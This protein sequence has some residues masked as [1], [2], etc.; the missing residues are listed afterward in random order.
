MPLPYELGRFRLVQPL[1]DDG[2]TA[3]GLYVDAYGQQVTIRTLSDAVAADPASQQAFRQGAYASGPVLE[4]GH[5][6]DGRPFVVGPA[7]PPTV[8][9]TGPAAGPGYPAYGPPKRR[10]WPLVAAICAIVV[11]A[12][13]VVTAVLLTRGDDSDSHQAD[14]ATLV[15]SPTSAGASSTAPSPTPSPTPT[16]D[17]LGTPH[18]GECRNLSYAAG[19]ALS[20]ATPT[21]DCEQTHTA[22]TYYVGRYQGDREDNDYAGY[23]CESQLPH[24][25]GVPAT[26]AK[27]SAYSLVF[28]Q[29][30]KQQW[31]A[32]ARWFRC[33]LVLP[34]PNSFAPLPATVSPLPS[35]LP[36]N[37][38]AC[39]TAGA[40]TPCNQP[41]VLR[42]ASTIT[43]SFSGSKLPKDAALV[44]QAKAKCPATTV[45]Y[46]WPSK[47]DWQRGVRLGVCWKQT[48]H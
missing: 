40:A 48:A 5:A 28:Y 13:A 46:T 43:Y 11:V 35:P 10:V 23:T 29:P 14:S 17:A 15:P 16:T 36:D 31:S 41:H 44:R 3:T 25:L 38:A 6:A 4:V 12:A 26:T 33:D 22:L 19:A 45:Y 47:G 42:A 18:V 39:R 32:G 30:T 1:A 27:L 21:V 9:P 20:D 2:R 37:L 8:P 24:A 7:G 34:T